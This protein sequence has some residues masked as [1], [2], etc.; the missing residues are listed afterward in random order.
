MLKLSFFNVADGDAALIQLPTEDGIFRILVD[1]GRREL[2]PYPGSLRRTV[3]QH[4]QARNITRLDAV[5][6]THLHEDHFGGLSGI[7]PLTSVAHVY[8]GFYPEA[9][10][11]PAPEDAPKTV[12]GLVYCLNEWERTARQLHAAGAVLH[13]V[14]KT[15]ALPVPEGLRVRLI[16]PDPMAAVDQNRIWRKMCVGE[17][18]SREEAYW[19]SK[20]RNPGSLRLELEYAGRR[21][22]LAGDCYG[23]GWQDLDLAPCDILKVPHHGDAKALTQ[24]LVNKLRPAQAVISC[25]AAYIS[26]KD[27]PSQEA[28]AMLRQAGSRVWFTD[29]FCAPCQQAEHWDSV[30]FT[31]GEDGSIRS[32]KL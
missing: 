30:D 2:E 14:T 3:A 25:G 17:P 10:C 4:L 27:R 12:R 20:W 13:P 24:T 7:L 6:V 31:I 18:V 5:I 16:C 11:R 19:S 22:I 9:P 23:E 26:R 8:A 29:S 15:A 28:I 1:A 32:P 21:V